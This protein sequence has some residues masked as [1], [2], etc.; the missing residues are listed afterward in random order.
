MVRIPLGNEK[1]ARIEV[2]SIAPDANPY[3][4]IYALLRTGLEGP[5][6]EEDE[7][8]QAA[9]HPLPAR[10]HLRRDPPLQGERLR[11]RPAGRGGPRQ[12]RRGEARLG[13]ALPEGA[14]HAG[15]DVRGA[16]PP[17]GHQPVPLVAVLDPGRAPRAPRRRRTGARFSPR[18]PGSALCAKWIRA[19]RQ[20]HSWEAGRRVDRCARHSLR[21]RAPRSGTRAR[22]RPTRGPRVPGLQAPRTPHFGRLHKPD[23][24]EAPSLPPSLRWSFSLLLFAAQEAVEPPP[25][26]GSAQGQRTAPGAERGAFEVVVEDARVGVELERVARQPDRRPSVGPGAKRAVVEASSQTWRVTPS[27]T[28]GR[29]R[30]VDDE[31]RAGHRVEVAGR[32]VE[33]DA[34]QAARRE[35]DHE[36]HLAVARVGRHLGRSREH[37]RRVVHLDHAR[38]QVEGLDGL[39]LDVGARARVD[40]RRVDAE[41]PFVAAATD[42]RACRRAAPRPSAGRRGPRGRS[43]ARGRSAGRRSRPAQPRRRG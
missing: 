8:R 31:E 41:Q 26:A 4:A 28:D 20:G 17:R 33:F 2:R 22:P 14:R 37:V 5:L 39:D 40:P 35:A 34:Q 21:N 36:G 15:Q 12:V 24:P 16:V 6:A 7:R 3:L 43:S 42:R 18:E 32:R 27:G 1:S 10:Q 25:A 30:Q 13:R 29:G 38:A 23:R 9:A 11:A 19:Y